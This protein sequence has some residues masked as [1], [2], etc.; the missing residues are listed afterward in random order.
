MR[1]NVTHKYT[2]GVGSCRKYHLSVNEI[3]KPEQKHPVGRRSDRVRQDVGPVALAP[4]CA[5]QC[6][7]FPPQSNQLLKTTY[8]VSF[9]LRNYQLCFVLPHSFLVSPCPNIKGFELL[10]LRFAIKS[11][12]RPA[13]L[14]Y[15]LFWTKSTECGCHVQQRLSASFVTPSEID[16]PSRSLVSEFMLVAEPKT[17]NRLPLL[18]DASSGC[19]PVWLSDLLNS[20][21]ETCALERLTWLIE[22]LLNEMLPQEITDSHFLGSRVKYLAKFWLTVLRGPS[23]A[24]SLC[25]L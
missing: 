2:S 22:S 16:S 21:S 6:S 14:P 11:F 15:Q 3:L 13:M 18:S 10:S 23:F 7:S 19:W 9:L 20:V 25:F 5:D 4:C 12:S 24:R 17:L 8:F 1:H